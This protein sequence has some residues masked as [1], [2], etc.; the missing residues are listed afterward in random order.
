MARH[1]Y[2]GTISLPFEVWFDHPVNN[3]D[4]LVLKIADYL[5]D[6]G[7]ADCDLGDVDYNYEEDN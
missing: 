5:T 1:Y 7:I 6:N 3:Y 2:S 4:E